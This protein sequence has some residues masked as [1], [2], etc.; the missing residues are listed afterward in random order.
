MTL[1]QKTVLDLSH[2]RNWSGRFRKVFQ[3]MLQIIRFIEMQ[4]TKSTKMWMLAFRKRILAKTGSQSPRMHNDYFCGEAEKFTFN[5]QSSRRQIQLN[6]ATEFWATKVRRTSLGDTFQSTGVL[7]NNIGRVL[8][9]IKICFYICRPVGLW[10]DLRLQNLLSA[11]TSEVSANLEKPTTPEKIYLASFGVNMRDTGGESCARR[12][13]YFRFTQKFKSVYVTALTP[14]PN[15]VKIGWKFHLL[16]NS[17]RM[18]SD[19][20]RF[21]HGVTNFVPI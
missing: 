4:C 1:S 5:V 20:A 18:C 16:G 12:N 8:K 14:T 15:L 21:D 11:Q 10:P 9:D 7:D 6:S 3:S 2:D 17:Q 19:V 13:I